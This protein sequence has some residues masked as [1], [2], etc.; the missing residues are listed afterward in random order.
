MNEQASEEMGGIKYIEPM[1]NIC[2][3]IL[4]RKD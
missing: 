4:D 2:L 3:H 1:V